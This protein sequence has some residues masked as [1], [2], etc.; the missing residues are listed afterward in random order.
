MRLRNLELKDVPL[1]FEWMHDES[2]VGKLK[3]KTSILSPVLAFILVSCTEEKGYAR[4]I[5]YAL[6]NI[7]IGLLI[8]IQNSKQSKKF[9]DKEFCKYALHFNIPLIA[10][11][12]SQV[13]FNQSDRIMIS[14][15]VGT[16]EAAM[17][18]VA[19][20]LSMI[21]NF[22]INAINASYVP[23]MYGKIKK[24]RVEENKTISIALVVLM[25]VM[26][27]CVI[28][29]A[30]EIILIMA[31]EQYETAIYVVAPVAMSLLILFYCQ[32]FINIEF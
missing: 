26:I 21:L 25:G 1:M 28:W 10:Y 14:H 31:G 30:P 11:Y 13:I 20:N 16:G 32:L 6:I 7:L 12:V 3:E 9:F 22:I 4:I 2:I 27:L 17:Y 18:G 8:F 29:F 5:G 23:W 24:G 15:M 19:Y